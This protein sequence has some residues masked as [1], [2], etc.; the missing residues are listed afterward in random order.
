MTAVLTETGIVSAL[1]HAAGVDPRGASLVR[2]CANVVYY[3][4]R[5]N[6]VVRIASVDMA[7]KARRAIRMAHW[8]EDIGFP[9]VRVHWDVP[10]VVI[11]DGAVATFWQYLPQPR[12]A[13]SVVRLAPLLRRLHNELPPFRLPSWDPVS[14]ARAN[15]QLAADTL[16]DRDCDFLLR[17]CDRLDVEL[18]SNPY[19]LP[20]GLIHGDAWAGN[21]LWDG[22]EV[23]LCDLDQMCHGPLEWDLVPT[24]VNGL[25]FGH[26][27]VEEFLGSYGFD[28]MASE[29]F[30]LLRQ[31]RELT[32]LTG[33]LPALSSRPSIAH[34][35]SRRI[36]NLRDAGPRRWTPYE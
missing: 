36:A 7:A 13:P 9:A 18:A 27:G 1:C 2:I 11:V 32:M 31:A 5:V 28:V 21:L 26:P 22:E 34:E 33:A 12:Q 20:Y 17:W 19:G 8:L 25:R 10:E 30:S 16:A 23:V 4:P 24:V 6:A 35:I 29:S 3:L 14:D 15:L